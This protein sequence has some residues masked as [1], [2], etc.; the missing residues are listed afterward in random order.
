M[1]MWTSIKE[2]L[3]DSVDT[4]IVYC[5]QTYSNHDTQHFVRLAYFVADKFETESSI[6]VTHW[7]PLPEFPK[8]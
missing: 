6:T 1:D 2:R 4:Y 3:P 5:T 8:D 7:M